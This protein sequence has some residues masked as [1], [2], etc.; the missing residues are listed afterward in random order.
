MFD[1]KNDP[2]DLYNLIDKNNSIY[3][4]ATQNFKNTMNNYITNETKDI[5]MEYL[6]F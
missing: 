2:Q 5:I 1:R 4:K 3:N 6:Q